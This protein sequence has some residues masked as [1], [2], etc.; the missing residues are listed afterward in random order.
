M[1]R[2]LEAM[3]FALVIFLVY[4]LVKSFNLV[5]ELN[6]SGELSFLAAFGLGV[7]ASTSTC[8]ATTGSLFLATIG[9]LNDRSVMPALFFN[10]GRILSYGVFGLVL[11]YAGRTVTYD[12]QLGQF[13]SLAVAIMM[14]L[15]G[16]DMAKL[17]SFPVPT[18]TKGLFERLEGMLIK[19]PKNTAFLLGGITYFLPCGFT[20]AVQLYA[21]GLADP[22]RSAIVLTVFALGTMPV[23]MLI[24]FTS[25]FASS[26][27]YVVFQKFVGILLII[28][29]LSYSNNFLVTRGISIQDYLPAS[30][31]LAAGLPE[32]RDGFQVVKM[33]VDRYGYSPDFFTVKKGIPVRWEIEGEVVYGCQNFLVVPTLNVQKVIQRGENVVEFLPEKEGTIHFSCSMGMYRGTFKVI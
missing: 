30:Q 1:N 15:I 22:V 13:V 26:K 21:F 11:G 3:A 5:P 8:M 25:S 16:L 32:V 18:F 17:I 12:L 2:F 31:K 23:L 4:F 20:Q 14:L 28:M 19:K 6:I 33:K 27:Y 9:K 7:I 24:G 29:G 10:V